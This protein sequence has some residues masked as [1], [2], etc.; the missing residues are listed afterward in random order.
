MQIGPQARFKG[1][2]KLQSLEKQDAKVPMLG[3]VD[4]VSPPHFPRLGN[5]AKSLTAKSFQQQMMF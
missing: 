5:L 2:Q 4:A 1:H 3:I